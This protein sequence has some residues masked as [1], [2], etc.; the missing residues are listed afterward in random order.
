MSQQAA[1][2][3]ALKDIFGAAKQAPRKDGFIENCQL[4][5][6][7]DDALFAVGKEKIYELKDEILQYLKDENPYFREQAIRVLGYDNGDGLNIPE[8][9][10]LAYEFWLNDPD[11]NVRYAALDEWSRCYSFSKDPKVLQYLYNIF[12]SDK[13]SSDIRMKALLNFMIVAEDISNIE[14]DDIF[15]LGEIKDSKLFLEAMNN[16]FFNKIEDIMK[17]YVNQAV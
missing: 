13:Y 6:D 11:D 15:D 7:L 8:I 14:V 12:H 10:E 4:G 3:K 16:R 17:K 2:T 5:H 9:K 1:R